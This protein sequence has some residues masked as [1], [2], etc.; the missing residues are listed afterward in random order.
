MDS[1]RETGTLVVDRGVKR[2]DAGAEAAGP[3]RKHWVLSSDPHRLRAEVATEC[4]EFVGG[5][6]TPVDTKPIGHLDG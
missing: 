3:S 2:A 5:V 6:G 4:G 1:V